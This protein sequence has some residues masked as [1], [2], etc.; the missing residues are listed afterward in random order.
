MK[1]LIRLLKYARPYW[2]LLIISG[3]S[4]LVITALNL[5]S[6]LLI[7]E[8]VAIVTEKLNDKS[9]HSIMIISVLLALSYI[10]RAVFRYLNNYLSHV[11]AWRLVADMRVIVYDHGYYKMSPIR[12]GVFK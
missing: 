10:A 3:I 7:K 12:T 4:L 6:P 2:G 5:L 1:N 9:M 11:A 8:M